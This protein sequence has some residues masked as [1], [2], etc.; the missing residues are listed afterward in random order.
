MRAGQVQQGNFA[1][2]P[3]LRI[4]EM[5]EIEVHIVDSKEAP[6][7]MGEGALSPAAPAVTNA[8]FALDGRRVRRLPLESQPTRVRHA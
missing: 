8:L 5:P 1:D 7:G 6:G 4:N 3:P 2:Y